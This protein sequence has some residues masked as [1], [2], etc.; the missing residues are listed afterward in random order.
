MEYSKSY[1]CDSCK[2][3]TTINL[4]EDDRGAFDSIECP[5]CGA[6]AHKHVDR[7]VVVGDMDKLDDNLPTQ[8][9]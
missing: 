6:V 4:A 3:I 9:M 5:K 2:E 7:T 1:L 8:T